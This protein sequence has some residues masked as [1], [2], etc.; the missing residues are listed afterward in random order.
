VHVRTGLPDAPEALEILS[1]YW[2]DIV[3]RYYGRAATDAEVRRALHDYP[4][5][6]LAPPTGIFLLGADEHGVI[7][8]AGLRWTDGDEAELARVFVAARGRGRGWARA[9]LDAAEQE[10]RASGRTE[11]TAEVRADLVEAQA[12]YESHGYERVA[13]FSTRR[14]A[15]VWLRKRLT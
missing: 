6:N 2:R 4:S 11:I 13:A 15:D 5:E 10:A 1:A 7:G 8:C 12:L 14:Y 9:L 3:G